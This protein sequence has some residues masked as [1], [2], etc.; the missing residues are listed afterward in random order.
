MPKTLNRATP[1]R[2]PS[3][4]PRLEICAKRRGPKIAH[5]RLRVIQRSDTSTTP[6]RVIRGA[7][8]HA[9]GVNDTKPH[10]RCERERAAG[11]GPLRANTPLVGCTLRR[12]AARERLVWFVW[13]GRQ[14]SLA[15]VFFDGHAAR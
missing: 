4:L 7:P 8:S 9:R 15:W 12:S 5:E 1:P 2:A 13:S 14:R 6:Y 10:T 3:R 11:R